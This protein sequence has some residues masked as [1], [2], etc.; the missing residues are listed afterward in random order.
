MYISYISGI[1]YQ[2]IKME[3]I[4]NNYGESTYGMLSKCG[5]IYE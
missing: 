2:C 1:I 3:L 4:S 5:W